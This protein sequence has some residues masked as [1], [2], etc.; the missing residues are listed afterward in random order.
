MSRWVRLCPGRR[1]ALGR[2]RPPSASAVSRG[3]E[4]IVAYEARRWSSSKKRCIN[5]SPKLHVLHTKSG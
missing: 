5:R 3:T 1:A 2:R 4:R